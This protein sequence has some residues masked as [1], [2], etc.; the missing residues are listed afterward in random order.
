MILVLGLIDRAPAESSVPRDI[1]TRNVYVGSVSAGRC[2]LARYQ[3]SNVIRQR[4][5]PVV[6]ERQ[7]RYR[8]I[9]VT[10]GFTG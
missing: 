2:I 6:D 10:R 7:V 4:G 5:E 3:S 8:E 9:I 1:Y